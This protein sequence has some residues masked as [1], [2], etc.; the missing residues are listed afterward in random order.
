MNKAAIKNF[1]IEA[2]KKLIA[3]V[4]DKAG[5]IG[6]TRDSITD[7]ISKGEGYAIFPTH[8]GIEAKLTGKEVKQRENL[9]NRIKSKENGYELVMEE[10]AYTWFNRLIALRFMEVNDYL[11]LRVRVLSSETAGKFEPD[12]VSQ[13]PE[14]DLEFSQVEIEEIYTLK[15]KNALDQLFRM[16]FIKQCNELGKILPELFENT[17]KENNDYT[18]ILLDISYTNEDGVLRDLLKIDE[19]DFLEAV[20][21]IGWMYQYY[22]TEPKDETFALLKKNVKITKERIPAATQLF[23]PDWI[24]RY[25]VENSLGRLW[26]EGHSDSDIKGNWKYY[27]DEAEQEEDVKAELAKLREERK[28]LRPEHIKV[29]DPCMGSGHILVYAFDVLMDIYKACG[30]TERDAA[31]LILQHNLYGLDIDDRAYQLAYFAVMMKARAYSRRILSEGIRPH[32]CAIQESNSIPKQE[33]MDIFARLAEGPLWSNKLRDDVAY[34]ID[35]FRDAKEYGAIIDIKPIDF[36]AIEETLDAIRCNKTILNIFDAPYKDTILRILPVLVEQGKLLSYKYDIVVTN[37]PYMGSSGMGAKLSEYV[38]KQYADSKSDLFAVFIEKGLEL[39]KRNGIN[40]MVTMQSWMFLSSFEKMRKKILAT[41]TISNLMHME[42]MVMGIAFGTAVA[43]LKNQ[44]IFG[45]KGTYNHIK[46]TDIG[47]KDIPNAF[48]I[49]N[50]RFSQVSA[51]N[52]FHIPGMPIAYWISQRMRDIFTHSKTLGQIV[53]VKHGLST[54]KNEAVVRTW[55]EISFADFG[56]GFSSRDAALNSGY[57]WFPYNKGGSFRKWYGN[58]EFVLRYDQYGND[59]MQTFSGHRHDGKSHYFKPSITWSFISSTKFGVRF[60]P[61]GAIFDV[62]GSSVFVDS[63][64]INYITA[65]LCSSLAFEFLQTL[66]PTLNFQVGNVASLP[67]IFP[68]SE[69]IKQRVEQL[70]Q[71]CIAISKLDWDSFENSW[72]FIQHPFLKYKKINC[73]Q[74]FNE[75]KKISENQF[76]TLKANEE[77]LNSIFIEIYGLQDE[78][79][80]E[81]EDRDITIRKADLQR[82]IRSFISYAVGCMFGRYSLDIEGLAYAGGVWDETKYTTLTPDTDNI[83]PITDEEYFTDDIVAR[84]VE[85]VKVVYGQETLEDN[86]DFIAE[87]LG[88]KGNTSREVIR[89]YFI[90]DFYADHVRV[91][92]KRPIYWL[93]DSG[94]ENGF[95]ALIYM[96]RYDQDTVGRVRADYL[97]KAQAYIENA[98]SHCDVVRESNAPASEKAKAVKQKEKL[99]KQLAETRLYDQAIAHIAHRR[100]AID[101]D[102][103]VAANY[104]KFQGIEVAN[105][106]K[107]TVK[108]DLLAKI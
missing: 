10:V 2:R 98:I 65:F 19:A 80:P 12:I 3:S 82:D 15:E 78:M 42:N 52:F 35:V 24:V 83:L 34:L 57:K 99:V 9:V 91:Y 63:Q 93:F 87:A 76:Q 61:N 4:K 50:N 59:L 21:I 17:S 20:E 8:I 43:V 67:I 105:E 84:F 1:A 49:M 6:I 69:K 54:G 13:A 71:S 96:H 60:S 102:D 40:C 47:E 64:S 97:H 56:R 22:N 46:L 26:L 89:N 31:K 33:V 68:H 55:T 62:A 90:K 103:G 37:P 53:E 14:V 29:I 73:V 100:I 32:L 58:F 70:A 86:L 106:G 104:A 38:K 77:Q 101:L 94:K 107:K 30:Y 27:L 66:N 48:P 45:Y 72:D 18:E 74:T 75:W 44:N 36:G 41:K 92:Q 108:I 95:K 81:V 88:N 79:P 39:V 23:T 11:P 85:F 7:P 16:L 28:N 5:R 25:M 51:T